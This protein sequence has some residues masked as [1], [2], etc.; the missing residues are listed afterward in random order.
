[1]QY[2]DGETVTLSYT[3]QGPLKGVSGTSVYVGD[4]STT[5]WGR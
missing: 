4:T 5:R 3:S 2:P 1:M